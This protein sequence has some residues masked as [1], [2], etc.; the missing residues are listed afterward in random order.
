MF[1]ESNAHINK[2]FMKIDD[3]PL[4]WNRHA[5]NQCEKK[6]ITML[7]IKLKKRKSLILTTQ[8]NLRRLKT[9]EKY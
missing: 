9:H 7:D 2:K 3:H 5:L 6:E 8:I 4:E 1:N